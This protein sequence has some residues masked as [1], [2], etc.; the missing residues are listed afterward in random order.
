MSM[1]KNQSHFH[2]GNYYVEII[3]QA[4]WISH[5]LIR[6]LKRICLRSFRM[7]YKYVSKMYEKG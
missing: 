1:K 6:F 4:V 5:H 3:T 7:F 2:L